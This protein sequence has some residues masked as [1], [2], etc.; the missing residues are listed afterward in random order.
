MANIQNKSIDLL[1]AY[2]LKADKNTIPVWLKYSIIPIVL[3]VLF[4]S[5]FTYHTLQANNYQKEI[6]TY[7][8]EKTQ[9][10]AKMDE[11]K[12][13]ETLELMTTLDAR[14]ENLSKVITNL[15]TYPRINRDIFVKIINA[16]AYKVNVQN[17]DF[18]DKTGALLITASTKDI[19]ETAAFVQRLKDTQL[20]SGV[21][22]NGYKEVNEAKTEGDSEETP[23]E[24]T[25]P[26]TKKETTP[27]KTDSS[28]QV[29]V[30]CYLKVGGQ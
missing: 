25:T 18:D 30:S 4:G 28:Y 6:D 24:E 9:L 5:V 17:I 7:K 13:S 26:E 27:T 21:D 12:V 20:F 14:Y 22:Y 10:Q 11:G 1:Q 2:K 16:C 15:S 8:K 23:S 3:I 19:N 29:V